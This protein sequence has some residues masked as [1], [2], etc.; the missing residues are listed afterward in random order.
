MN[1]F[2]KL[3]DDL[4]KHIALLEK[5]FIYPFIP[6]EPSTMPDKYEHHVKAYCILCHAAFEEYFETIALRVMTK[7][8]DCWLHDRKY[9]DTLVTLVSYYGLKL[10]VNL[11]ES[12]EEIKIFDYLRDVFDEVKKMF[13]KDVYENHGISLKYLRSLLIPVAIDIK[14]DVNLLNSLRKLAGERG[15]YAHK[16]LI[17]NIL[18]PEDAKNYVGDCLELCKDIKE[19]AISKFT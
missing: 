18:S 16:R 13:S 7:S 8:I 5:T 11:D 1:D 6:A 15:E 14:N 19:K 12:N 2:E 3:Y 9:N 4:K 17:K 10:K